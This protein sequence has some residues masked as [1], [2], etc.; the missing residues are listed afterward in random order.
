MKKQ[1]D[2]KILSNNALRISDFVIIITLLIITFLIFI[3]T[4]N[5]DFIHNWDDNINITENT[6]I[7]DFSTHGIATLF[8]EK[9]PISEPRLTL[10]TYMIQYHFWNL[11][12]FPYHLANVIIHILNTIFVFFLLS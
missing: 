1:L 6:Y 8:S 9:T 10:F 3:N 7:K 2:T 5:S 11:N 4:L 12:P